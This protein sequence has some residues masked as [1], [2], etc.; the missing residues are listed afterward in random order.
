MIQAMGLMEFNSIAKGIEAADGMIKSAPVDILEAK[1]ICPGK[2]I[3][4]VYGDVSAVE[5]AIKTGGEIGAAAVIDDFILPNVHP[6]VIPAISGTSI[7][8]DIR[9][10]GVVEAFSVASLIVAADIA[11]KAGAVELIEIRLGLGIGGKSFLTLTGDVDSVKVAIER[12]AASA[13]EKGMLVEQVVI[14][15]P[16]RNLKKCLL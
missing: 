12:G 16:H 13:S 5:N 4:L 14:P 2:Y 11:V 15:S 3:V 10:L 7:V 9:A 6:A 8:E 1:P